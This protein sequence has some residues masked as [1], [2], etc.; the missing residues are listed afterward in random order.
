MVS[1]RKLIK[2]LKEAQEK[3]CHE[4]I[5]KG[6][7][8]QTSFA[9]TLTGKL[10]VGE[11]TLTTVLVKAKKAHK[12]YEATQDFGIYGDANWTGFYADYMLKNIPAL[13]A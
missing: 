7:E 12:E 13:S 10:G 4:D 6:M 2:L 8:F 1:K 9:K 5:V 11:R 3:F